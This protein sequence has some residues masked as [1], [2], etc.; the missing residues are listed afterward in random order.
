MEKTQINE[1]IIASTNKGKLK[2]FE[3]IFNSYVQLDLKFRS[4]DEVV[5]ENF[6]V[7]ETG[8][9]FYENA[10]L[11]AKAGAQLSKR[12]TLADDSGIEITALDGRPG[13]YSGRYLKSPEGGINGVLQ[14]LQELEAKN[15]SIDR[16]CRFVCHLVLC[17]PNG[18]IVFH[19]EEYWNGKISH[20][21]KGEEGFGFDPIVYPD[22]YPDQTV[23]QL[24]EKLKNQLSHRSQAVKALASFLA[25]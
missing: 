20:E 3:E 25:K 14:E 10:V 19:T 2:E 4:I 17:D 22:E 6:D 15:G 1:I 12:Y 24:G 9:T 8:S 7:D 16:S 5:S 18:E 13:I 23:A 21:I 11:K